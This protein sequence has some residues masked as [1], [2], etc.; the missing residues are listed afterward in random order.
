MTAQQL[1]NSILQLAVQGKLVPQ[2]GSDEPAS[3]LLERIRAEKAQL[4]KAGKIKKSKPL[5]PASVEEIPFDLPSGWEWCRLGEICN[6]GECQNKDA[7]DINPNE[8]LLDLEDIEKDSG[9]LLQRKLKK[10]T[11]SVSTKHCFFKG[12]VLYSKLRPYLNKVI[13]A[14]ENGYCTSEILPLDFGEVY[15]RYAQVFLMSPLFVDYANQCS[16]GVKMPRLGTQDGRNALTPLPPLAE[17]HRIVAKIEELL[18]HIADY[19]IAEKQLT[20][21]TAAFPVQ[22]KKSILQAAVQGKLVEQCE[23]DEPASVLL[24]RI[25]A[26]RER[27]VKEGKIKKSKSLPPVSAEE[28]PFDL[29]CGWVWCRL[30]EVLLKLTDGTHYTPKYTPSG[31][32]FLSVKDMSNGKLNFDNTKFVSQ[33]E[34]EE[35]FKR[36]NPQKG[37]ILLTKVG[38]TGIPVI[39]DTD[40]EF[41][42]FVSVALLKFNPNLLLDKYLMYLIQS[43]LVSVQCTENTRGVGNKNWVIRDIAN[44][45]IVL[46]PFAEQERIVARVEEL[47]GVVGG[48]LNDY[49]TEN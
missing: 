45:I 7:N 4:V 29:P 44:T 15:N 20:A 28:I 3:V 35:L 9:I 21:L 36:C 31:V 33:E 5:P 41:S 8:W 37:D 27:L 13:I 42:L 16:Y 47:L 30:G 1:K 40:R 26:E 14:D 6:L 39:V 25:C 19:D 32:P 11:K 2:C 18:P 22:L 49:K 43:P 34:H 46:P 24:E 48:R 23:S 38:T 12:Q 10:D 17:Q